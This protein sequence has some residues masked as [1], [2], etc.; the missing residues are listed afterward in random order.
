MGKPTFKQ[1]NCSIPPQKMSSKAKQ[2]LF[3]QLIWNLISG[4]ALQW[5]GLHF[6]SECFALII[7]LP[8]EE[9][10][11]PETA[12]LLLISHLPQGTRIA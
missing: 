12:K 2:H 5:D 3:C 9:L 10:R 11:N 6:K 8:Q 4:D 1:L 7:K